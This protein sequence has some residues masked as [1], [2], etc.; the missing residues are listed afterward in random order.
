MRLERLVESQRV[1]GDVAK[2]SKLVPQEAVPL[3]P[4]CPAPG[5]GLVDGLGADAQAGGEGAPGVARR[6]KSSISV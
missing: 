3:G 6:A 5:G 4:G 2:N 1:M